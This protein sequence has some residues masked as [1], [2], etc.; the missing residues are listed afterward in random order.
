VPLSLACVS[1]KSGASDA[2]ASRTYPHWPVSGELQRLRV[3]GGRYFGSVPLA[4]PFFAR[5][6]GDP[7][8]SRGGVRRNWLMTK[9]DS[10]SGAEGRLRAAFARGE[11]LDLRPGHPGHDDPSGGVGWAQLPHPDPRTRQRRPRSHAPRRAAC[12]GG[13]PR[14]R[15]SRTNRRP[16]PSP[17]TPDGQGRRPGRNRRRPGRRRGD[18]GRRRRGGPLGAHPRRLSQGEVAPVHQESAA[19]RAGGGPGVAAILI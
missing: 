7:G 4:V 11:V 12:H 5:V 13:R 17:A 9:R 1:A 8:R 19:Y 18:S 10:P 15:P 3:T 14:P 2:S 6:F 16:P